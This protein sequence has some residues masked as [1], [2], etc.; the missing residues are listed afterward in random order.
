MVRPAAQ[1]RVHLLLALLVSTLPGAMCTRADPPL[2]L[3]GDEQLTDGP[4][5]IDQTTLRA[6]SSGAD[7]QL[8]GTITSTLSWPLS[9]TIDVA[10]RDLE[11]TPIASG[12]G[13]LS[14][15]GTALAFDVAVTPAPRVDSEDEF[16]RYVLHVALAINGYQL[17]LRRSLYLAVERPDAEVRMPARALPGAPLPLV[18]VQSPIADRG[19]LRALTVADNSADERTLAVAEFDDRGAAAAL[20]AVPA[21]VPA[22]TALAVESSDAERRHRLS[23]GTRV[24]TPESV[25]LQL[26]GDSVPPGGAID[27]VVA[28]RAADQTAAAQRS[29]QLCLG[30]AGRPA[31]SCHPATSDSA[32]IAATRFEI[33]PALAGQQLS[34][35]ADFA[36]ASASR[37]LAVAATPAILPLRVELTDASADADG[38]AATVRALGNRPGQRVHSELRLDHALGPLVA[39]SDGALTSAVSA[40]RLP[41]PA[42][43][44]TRDRR[45]SVLAGVA[46]PFGRRMAAAVQLYAGIPALAVGVALPDSVVGGTP[47]SAVVIVRDVAGT[48]VAANGTVAIGNALHPF[49]TIVPGVAVVADLV[50][51]GADAVLDIAVSDD[52]GRSASLAQP[53]PV[54]TSGQP[55]IELSVPPVVPGVGRIDV[56]VQVQDLELV[57]LW[58]TVAGIALDANFDGLAQCTL[59]AQ[60]G[61]LPTTTTALAVDRAA[62]LH[63]A[64]QLSL[65]PTPATALELLPAAG[66]T[67]VP[68]VRDRSGVVQVASVVLDRRSPPLLASAEIDAATAR[69]AI[70]RL[71]PAL[72]SAVARSVAGEAADRTATL[73]ATTSPAAIAISQARVVAD[74]AAISGDIADRLARQ[75]LTA[76]ELPDWVQRRA[77]VYYDPW[78]Q[79]YQLELR[80]GRLWLS[81]S[82]L[83]E[84]T[85]T[86]DDVFAS[87]YLH[88]VLLPVAPAELPP[89]ARADWAPAIAPVPLPVVA[90]GTALPDP[91]PGDLVSAHTGDGT[92]L[93]AVVDD[94]NRPRLE[95]VAPSVLSCRR[96][97]RF[98]LQV[99]I[100]GRPGRAIALHATASD[101]DALEVL[102]TTP[103]VVA[104]DGGGQAGAAI[105]LR[106][107]SN[108]PSA[109]V[110]GAD[111][112]ERVV[113]ATVHL[114]PADTDQDLVVL[115]A[116][117]RRLDDTRPL[118]IALPPAPTGSRRDITLRGRLFAGPADLV[119]ATRH[120]LRDRPS[121]VVAE[122]R[123]ALEATAAGAIDCS[124]CDR[125]LALLALRY[126]AEGGLAADLGGPLNTD[127]TLDAVE[128]L[129]AAE[130]ALATPIPLLPP[131]L[132]ALAQRLDADGALAPS[133][134]ADDAVSYD[135]MRLRTTAR[136]ARLLALRG[137][138]AD[139]SARV[140]GFVREHQS[141]ADDALTLAQVLRALV[142]DPLAAADVAPVGTTLRNRQ[143]L[144]SATT[145]HVGAFVGLPGDGPD[146]DPLATALALIALRE[147]DIEPTDLAAAVGYLVRSAR[148]ALPE[149]GAP[150][151]GAWLTALAPLDATAPA[152]AQLLLSDGQVVDLDSDQPTA[153]AIAV[154]ADQQLSVAVELT[155]GSGA[156]LM[157]WTEGAPVAPAASGPALRCDLPPLLTLASGDVR[158]VPLALGPLDAA[159][160]LGARSA[161]CLDVAFEVDDRVVTADDDG[162]LR[163][164]V[165]PRDPAPAVNLLLWATCRADL[166]LPIVRATAVGQPWR[167]T[168][169]APRL[170]QI[171]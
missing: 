59:G 20:V 123:N 16:A 29:G 26:G 98:S 136:L 23:T 61:A 27:V 149:L 84:Q 34:V 12:H 13:A 19:W 10:L 167:Q 66:Q 171:R 161:P 159:T 127:A 36:A 88:D 69:A 68:V 168:A 147:A 164:V 18:A 128:A 113:A 132:S 94:P 1:L 83:D 4:L 76:A 63:V 65:A 156:I 67:L 118:T 121:D 112:G 51:T 41:T 71:A 103:L 96:N 106:V 119:A 45:W 101:P 46:D 133:T 85:A 108:V 9:G 6:R 122:I 62:R 117:A 162:L 134:G 140:S 151:L 37:S 166:S 82:G 11:E 57:A 100:A 30:I 97:D 50:A 21:D 7:L 152:R 120:L 104:S 25:E 91:L 52:A 150:A 33:S 89:L 42:L 74:L 44:Q 77:R 125:Q 92:V 93:T 114:Q 160:V 115:A 155:A 157:L 75:D 47:F 64:T 56:V 53:L 48:L 3:S 165:L 58:T 170:V 70:D 35:S 81:S 60:P 107:R 169:T 38:I 163:T 137:T 126:T 143:Q 111:D 154:A 146:R 49:S 39:E 141:E 158:R 99:A 79:P 116:V 31:F 32:G 86:A 153:A 78:G 17:R 14:G 40:L 5:A 8:R 102:T 55:R 142:V 43:A 109:L 130:Q 148:P 145:E 124:G 90:A 72:Q 95:L 54:A 73:T 139:S 129:L 28:V 135:R 131:L 110:I 138:E 2:V 87:R 105:E 80:D 15:D 24:V 144:D 22:G